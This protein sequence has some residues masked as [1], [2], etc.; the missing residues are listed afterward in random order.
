M[1]V[2]EV[3]EVAEITA[4]HEGWQLGEPLDVLRHRRFGWFGPVEWEVKASG[5]VS[6]SHRWVKIDDQSGEFI[7]SGWRR[8]EA[9]PF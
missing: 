5:P 2:G 3:V 6:S 9:R 4:R 8:D 1:T 7:A